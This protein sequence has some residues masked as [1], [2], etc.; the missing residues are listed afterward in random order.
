M[1]NNSSS[2]G[3][4]KEK[5]R[6]SLDSF[7]RVQERMVATSDASWNNNWNR[8]N[9]NRKFKDYSLEEIEKIINSGD[10]ESQ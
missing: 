7:K 9:F 2:E 4:I 5:A 6:F 1:L 10:A 3:A 8:Y